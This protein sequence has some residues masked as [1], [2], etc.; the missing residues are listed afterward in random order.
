MSG[1]FATW[2]PLYAEHGIATLLNDSK[3]PAI[4]AWNKIGLPASGKFAKK[5]TEANALGFVTNARNKITVLDIDTTDEKVLADALARHGQ[6]PMVV[7]T[8]SGKAH[9]YYRHNSER[10]RIRPWDDLPIDLL[11]A[12]GLV[13]APPS[14]EKRRSYQFIAGSLDDIDRLPKMRGL[15]AD[16]Y[17]GRD[18]CVPSDDFQRTDDLAADPMYGMREHDGRNNALFR[19]IGPEARSIHGT[20][21]TLDDLIALASRYNTRAAEP[22]DAAEV[23]KIAANVAHDPRRP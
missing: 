23:V 4:K 2:Q 6:T 17:V 13:V 9:A 12:G 18:L 16:M 21:G 15:S 1:R 3:R 7:R 14:C 22:L 20:D 5:F 11:G 8:A 10:R 19:A